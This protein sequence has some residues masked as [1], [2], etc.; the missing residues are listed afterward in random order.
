MCGIHVV[1]DWQGGHRQLC[2]GDVGMNWTEWLYV[3]Y[4]YASVSVICN[5]QE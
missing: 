5:V 4:L 3:G 2:N 1:Q